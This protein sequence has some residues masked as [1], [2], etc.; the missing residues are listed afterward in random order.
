[1]TRIGAPIMAGI[2]WL[3][4][5]ARSAAFARVPEN[6]QHRGP[7]HPPASRRRRLAR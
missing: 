6:W 7:R 5:C 1:M 4:G 3:V 2:V